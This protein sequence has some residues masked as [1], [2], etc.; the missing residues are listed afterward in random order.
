MARLS[1]VVENSSKDEYEK[2]LSTCFFC[3]QEIAKGGCWAGVHHIGVCE[4]CSQYLGDLL[5]DTLYDCDDSFRKADIN[6]KIKLLNE[7]IIPRL[8]KKEEDRIRMEKFENIKSLELRYCAEMGIIDFFEGTMTAQEYVQK[9]DD[10]SYYKAENI[11]GCVD[12]IKSYIEELSGEEPHTIRFFGIP[13]FSYNMFRIAC[14]AK[15]SNNGSTFILC[16]DKG[17]LEAIDSYGYSPTIKKV[18]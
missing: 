4:N 12:E 2:Q 1:K 11:Y 6:K 5:I 15:I 3:S 10:Y 13:D 8:T 7:I 17:Y 16:N 9:F 18:Y 14:V